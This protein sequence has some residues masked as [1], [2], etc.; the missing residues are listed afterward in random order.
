VKICDIT[1]FYATKSGGVKTYLLRKAN[2]I[3]QNGLSDCQH[4]LILPSTEDKIETKGNS[5]FH[6]I[7]SPETLFWKPYRVIV[8]KKGWT[9]P[10][11]EKK[12]L[13]GKR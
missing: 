8:N 1:H 13:Y 6:F 12:V 9:Y 10:K 3:N 11:V 2:Y 7:G 5:N 4:F